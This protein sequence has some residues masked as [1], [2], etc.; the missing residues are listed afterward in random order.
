MERQPRRQPPPRVEIAAVDGSVQVNRMIMTRGVE[1][2]EP[3]DRANR[4]LAADGQVVAFA[5]FGN[6]GPPTKVT[7][8]WYRDDALASSTELKV[9]TAA[10]W[11]T[12]SRS[13]VARG[14]WRVEITDQ[15][16]TLLSESSF[17]VE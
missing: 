11:R 9:G 2:R 10:S 14:A 4:F 5:S 12:W 16:G 15:N 6:T 3:I 8:S 13:G 7:F 17:T 1:N